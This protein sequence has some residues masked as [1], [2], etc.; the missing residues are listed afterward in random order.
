MA[1]GDGIRRNIAHVSAAERDRFINAVVQLNSRYYPDGVSKWVKQDEIHEATHVHGGPSF[2]PWHREL[3]NRYEELLREI[4][5]Q[6]S[7]HYWDWTQ[8]PRAADDGSGGTVNLFTSDFMGSSSG[9]AGDPFSGFPPFTRDLDA[10]APLVDPDADI[11]A[12]TNGEDQIDQFPIF[13]TVLESVPNHDRVH[14][15][16]GGTIGFAHTA[17]E[18]P[19][20]YL[21]HSNVDRIWAKWQTEP[22][23]EWRLDPNLTYG[24]ETADISITENLEP[25]AGGL[26]LRPWASPDNQQEIKNSKHISVVMPPCY[27]TN[28]NMAPY[29]EVE[30]TGT[31]PVVNFNDIPSGDT[32]SRAAVFNVYGC[33]DATIRVKAGFEPADPFS[34]LYPVSGQITASHS[35]EPYTTVRIWIGYTAGTANVAVPNGSVTFECVESGQEF[36]FVITANSI[37]RPRVAVMLALDQSGSMNSDAGTSGLRRVDVLKDAATKFMEVIPFDNGVGLIRFDHDAYPTNDATYPGLAI[38]RISNDLDRVAGIAAVSSHQTNPGGATSVGDGIQLARDLID[39]IPNADYEEKAL[40]VF[41][42]GHENSPVTI[43][44]VSGSI[45]DRTFA[46]GLGN[47][48]QVD[49]NALNSLTNGTGGYLK[50]TGILSSSIDDYFRVPKYFLQILAGVTNNNIILDPTGYINSQQVIKIPF[51]VNEAD[52]D[53]TVILLVDHQVVDM[54]IETPNGDIIDPS[55]AST[56]GIEYHVGQTSKNY[57]FSLPVAFPSDNHTGVWNV[58]LNVDPKAY[59][60]VISR[61]SDNETAA[62]NS[63][64][65]HGAK[66]SVI[67]NTYS[68]LKMS[69][70]IHQNGLEPGSTI[71][72]HSVLTEYGLPIEQRANIHVEIVRPDAS[73]FTLSLNEIEPGIFENTFVANLSGTYQCRF[74]AS[75]ATIR[76]SQFTREQTLNA[77]AFHDRTDLTPVDPSGSGTV[78]DKIIEKCCKRMS[79]FLLGILLVLIVIAVI[80]FRAG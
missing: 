41:T 49:T 71:T 47:E 12:S 56:L 54:R 40:I 18:D 62:S 69:P 9:D 3:I 80:L 21:L 57:K 48:S 22:G 38:T 42:D 59:K 28:S 39:A 55:N 34:I 32:A 78:I 16:I 61:L 70:T 65:A 15:Y 36:E 43:D 20:V 37:V 17:F 73:Q 10:G 6:L 74:L 77:S 72:L 30:N 4:D 75:G 7:L 50:L 24:S 19:F 14:G 5:P 1:L 11:I 35:P 31:P 23:E 29:V 8:D 76:G 53:A 46:I 67:I 13:R 2:L 60:K 79:L 66:Y 64:A 68:N 45:N 63:L 51:V 25:W 58:I 26:G 33:S 27:D 52:L 44:S